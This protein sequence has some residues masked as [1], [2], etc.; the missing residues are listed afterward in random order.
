MTQ[1]FMFDQEWNR[2]PQKRQFCNRPGL[3]RHNLIGSV[4][5]GC[6]RL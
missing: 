4:L 6:S 3:L 2:D 5:K 1:Q